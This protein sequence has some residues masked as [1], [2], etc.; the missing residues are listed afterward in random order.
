MNSKLFPIMVL[1]WISSFAHSPAAAQDTPRLETFSP[2]AKC[3]TAEDEA[4][5]KSDAITKEQADAIVGELKKIRQVLQ[6]QQ[7]QLAR[8]MVPQPAPAAAPPQQVQMNIC[9]SWQAAAP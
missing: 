9:N 5:A 7:V 8:A 3:L 4:A 1:T 2:G 6:N